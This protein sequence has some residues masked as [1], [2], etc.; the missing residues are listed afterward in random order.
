MRTLKRE[1]IAL[2]LLLFM[3]N[4]LH[5]QTEADDIYQI[6]EEKEV[7]LGVGGGFDYGGMAG[8]KLEYLPVKKVGL[9]FGAGYNLVSLGWNLGATY[10]F[11]PDKKVSPNIILMYGYNAVFKGMEYAEKYNMTSYGFTVGFNLDLKVGDQG[12]KW[13]FG[14]FLPFRSNKFMDNYNAAKGDSGVEMKSELMPI[15]VSFGYNFRI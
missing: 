9:F 13:S 3:C 14:L 11:T 12:N 7:Y 5:A 15:A 1:L 4:C 8:G 2:L 6:E 10:K